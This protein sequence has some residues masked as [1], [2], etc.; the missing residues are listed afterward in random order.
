MKVKNQWLCLFKRQSEL[1]YCRQSAKRCSNSQIVV[2]RV[3]GNCTG[4]YL[5]MAG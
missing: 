4:E 1:E 5:R 3:V 2:R